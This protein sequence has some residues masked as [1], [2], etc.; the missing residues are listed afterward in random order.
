MTNINQTQR[1]T[2][3]LVTFARSFHLDGID[4]SLP[5]GKYRVE[6]DEELLQGVSFPAYRR[7]ATTLQRVAEPPQLN[8]ETIV[9]NDPRQLDLALAMDQSAAAQDDPS[10]IK[11]AM[12]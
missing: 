11:P 7:T 5:A 9:I 10:L 3:R 6:T 4:E 1:T 12:R 2:T 8:A